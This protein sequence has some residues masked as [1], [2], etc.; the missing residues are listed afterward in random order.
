MQAVYAQGGCE[1]PNIEN[2]RN[3]ESGWISC[4]KNIT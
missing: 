3:L 4:L 2:L 1:E